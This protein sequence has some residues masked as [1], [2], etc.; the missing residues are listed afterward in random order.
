MVKVNLTSVG[1]KEKT[2]SVST[3]DENKFYK[4]IAQEVC[5][6]PYPDTVTVV[7]PMGKVVYSLIN[8]SGSLC[9][10]EV[11]NNITGLK[12]GEFPHRKLAFADWVTAG[13]RQSAFSG[14]NE[15]QMGMGS[16]KFYELEPTDDGEV[17][18]T[19]G[20]MRSIGGS[21]DA[22]HSCTYPTRMAWIK[23]SEKVKKGYFDLTDVYLE[24]EDDYEEEISE[25]EPEKK[26][27]IYAVALYR[28]LAD[29]VSGALEYQ[30]ADTHIT[31]AMI[32]AS[33]ETLNEL[34][35]MN[36]DTDEDLEKF[37]KTLLKLML[38]CP[39]KVYSMKDWRAVDKDSVKDILEREQDLVDAM[40]GKLTMQRN[41]KASEKK[42]LKERTAKLEKGTEP[43]TA[44]GINVGPVSAEVKSKILHMLPADLQSKVANVYRV[45]S[46]KH[47]ERFQKY[48]KDNNLTKSD[49]KTLWHGSRNENWLSIIEKGLMIHP[50]AKING[51]M[52]GYGIY[53]APSAQKSWGYTSYCGSYW[54]QG[55]QSLA[56][57]GLYQ[58]AYGKPYHPNGSWGNQYD[59]KFMK[60]HGC[61]CLH[62]QRHDC[63]LRNDEI[64][65]YDE[66]AMYLSYIVE[67]H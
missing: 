4:K 28:V 60:S 56:F 38:V 63:G 15:S 20:S 19:W 8:R 10:S 64:V 43:F 5:D 57:M 46:K 16:Y 23:Y 50:N 37:N 66:A 36:I 32:K 42:A 51:K 39:R 62:T 61:N 31:K 40:N 1:G 59:Q 41:K 65:F 29:Q 14:L 47:R 48:L 45:D 27:N 11:S 9:V 53:F 21:F 67:F 35:Q 22:P 6:V 12:D 2:F 17:K 18:A 25:S 54:A 13:R 49:I 34:Y 44:L 30:M 7:T 33:Q 24:T 55:N 58:C 3:Q 52:F 26:A